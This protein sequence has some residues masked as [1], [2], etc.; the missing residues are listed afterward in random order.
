MIVKPIDL[1]MI[2]QMNEVSQIKQQQLSKPVVQQ[3]NIAVQV[4]KNAEV[5]SEQVKR[6]DDPENNNS[7]K[8]FDAKE[9]SNNEYTRNGSYKKKRKTESEG[10]VVVK[11]KDFV[12]FDVKI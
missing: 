10:K 8:K 11:N 2:Q 12:D 1:A 3:Q 4:E 6:K 9:K 7:E 5:K